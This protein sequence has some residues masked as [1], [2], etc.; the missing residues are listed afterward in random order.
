MYGLDYMELVE[1]H[2]NLK[3]LTAEYDQYNKQ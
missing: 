2:S 1:A 3:D